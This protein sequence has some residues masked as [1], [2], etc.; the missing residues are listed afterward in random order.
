MHDPSRDSAKQ[1]KEKELQIPKSA[2]RARMSIS[3]HLKPPPQTSRE[4]KGPE[5]RQ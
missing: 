1:S 3:A 4:Y 2:R 5:K